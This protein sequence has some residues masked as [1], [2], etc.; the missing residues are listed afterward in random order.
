MLDLDLKKGVNPFKTWPWPR[1]QSRAFLLRKANKS[2]QPSEQE[3]DSWQV[4]GGRSGFFVAKT[5]NFES[6]VKVK[7][8]RDSTH[9]LGQDQA[10]S[11]LQL[12]NFIQWSEFS[13]YL[14]RALKVELFYFSQQELLYKK[15][16][17]FE[18]TEKKS[19]P[20]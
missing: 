2:K 5:L 13:K 19:K 12:V 10:W 14:G 8:F 7:F 17:I 20:R 3:I 1:S 18:S 6:S 9:F 15:I 4:E 11:E 16:S